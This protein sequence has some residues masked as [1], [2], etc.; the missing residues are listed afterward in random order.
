[1]EARAK[2]RSV[3]VGLG[4]TPTLKGR[5]RNGCFYDGRRLN[6]RKKEAER[7]VGW[8]PEGAKTRQPLFGTSVCPRMDVAHF[9][10]CT[11]NFFVRLFLHGR[12]KIIFPSGLWW[13]LA[14]D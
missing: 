2:R 12:K 9:S 7:V 10:A 6:R 5:S 1:M 14:N 3:A 4:G 8:G 13:H 11:R